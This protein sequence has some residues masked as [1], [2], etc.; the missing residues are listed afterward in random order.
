MSLFSALL[1]QVIKPTTRLDHVTDLPV[2]FDVRQ[3][4]KATEDSFAF[5][6]GS[7]HVIDTT[8]NV[9]IDDLQ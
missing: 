9:V 7:D 3:A 5:N 1:N 2:S 6:L 4:I 8:I